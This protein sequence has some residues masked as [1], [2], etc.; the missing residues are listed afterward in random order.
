MMLG[1]I[2]TITNQK[3]FESM[4]FL[5]Y[6]FSFIKFPFFHRFIYS[7]AWDLSV[8]YRYTN[9]RDFC[10]KATEQRRG[11]ILSTTHINIITLPTYELKFSQ[12]YKLDTPKASSW[13]RSTSRVSCRCVCC[14]PHRIDSSTSRSNPA[15]SMWCD[16]WYVHM[17]YV[18]SCVFILV[19]LCESICACNVCARVCACC[20]PRE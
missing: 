5:F 12:L 20:L 13:I 10:F 1:R 16:R 9:L 14:S 7:G 6:C 17:L 2:L 15:R 8:E 3:F 4:Y 11:M 18:C 19:R